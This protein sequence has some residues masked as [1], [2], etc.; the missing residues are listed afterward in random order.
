MSSFDD[1]SAPF[2]KAEDF[3]DECKA[4]TEAEYRPLSLPTCIQQQSRRVKVLIGLGF[5]LTLCFGIAG[6]YLLRGTIPTATFHSGS[7]PKDP[8][9]CAVD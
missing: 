5:L 6:G 1:S 2:L 4:S 7:S 8:S 3:D 9:D